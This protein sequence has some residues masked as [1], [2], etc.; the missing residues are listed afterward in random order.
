ME[1]LRG[2]LLTHYFASGEALGT[3]KETGDRYRPLL[4][5]HCEKFA[6]GRCVSADLRNH[7]ELKGIRAEKPLR[8]R[9]VITSHTV[10]VWS[11][12]DRYDYFNYLALHEC[13][14]KPAQSLKKS[15]V[16]PV[17]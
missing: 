3:T 4:R 17:S 15:T 10:G 13:S 5:T 16:S 8:R 7:Q 11:L 2:L 12:F 6:I 1:S 9:S 14:D